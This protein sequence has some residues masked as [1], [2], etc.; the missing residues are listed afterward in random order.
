[1]LARRFTSLASITTPRYAFGVDAK[2]LTIGVP[3]EVTAN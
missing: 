2:Q 3:K 1:M